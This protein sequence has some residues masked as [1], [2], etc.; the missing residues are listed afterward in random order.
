MKA[1]RV[2]FL[3]LAKDIDE[4]IIIELK[5]PG[6]ASSSTRFNDLIDIRWP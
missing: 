5:R 1:K 2:D 3:A 4:L 6:H